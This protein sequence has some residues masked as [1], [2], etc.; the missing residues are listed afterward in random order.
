[1]RKLNVTSRVGALLL[2]LV[3]VAPLLIGCGT[4][5]AA[6][7]TTSEIAYVGALDVSYEG[8]LDAKSQLALGT[9]QL[10]GTS[11]AVTETQATALVMVNAETL[12]SIEDRVEALHGLGVFTKIKLLEM[13][14][15]GGASSLPG[16]ALRSKVA[17]DRLARLKRAYLGRVRIG[18]PLWRVERHGRGCRLGQKDLVVGPQGQLAGCS[19]LL[20]VNHHQGSWRS[21]RMHESL[22]QN[23]S[24]M[25]ERQNSIVSTRKSS[26]TA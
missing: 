22:Q 21:S 14:P 1:M 26:A 18:T 16:S 10:E 11:D 24:S 12:D 9:L 2:V 13:L 20:Y 25:R 6:D 15:I 5:V 17:L 4:Q 3:L 23:S 7:A 8:A 19:L